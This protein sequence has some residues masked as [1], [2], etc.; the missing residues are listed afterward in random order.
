MKF[1]SKI[2]FSLI[3]FHL[4]L[5][6]SCAR[7]EVIR[8]EQCLGEW[9]MVDALTEGKRIILHPNGR[10]EFFIIDI[11]DFGREEKG[12]LPLVG[13]WRIKP[14]TNT[15]AFAFSFGG[16]NYNEEAKL[17]RSKD[18]LELWFNVGDP[19]EYLWKKFRLVKPKSD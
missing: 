19:D 5:I 8:I 4:I 14:K 12:R 7:S 16:G 10:A 6:S 3:G 15:L 18:K 13:D 9:K 1:A 2:I 17:K 11:E